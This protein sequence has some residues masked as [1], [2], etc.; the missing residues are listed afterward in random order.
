MAISERVI[1]TMFV[2][3]PSLFFALL[4]VSGNVALVQG[5]ANGAFSSYIG[6]PSLRLY[7]FE[8]LVLVVFFVLG[9][10]SIHGTKGNA[11]EAY[12][13]A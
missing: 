10:L 6:D 11:I 4:D 1:Q 2:L 13:G 8:G 12:E 3:V 5:A 7:L 9:L